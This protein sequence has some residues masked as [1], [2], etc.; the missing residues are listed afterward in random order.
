MQWLRYLCMFAQRLGRRLIQSPKRSKSVGEQRL[1]SCQNFRVWPFDCDLNLH[2][3]NGVYPLWLDLARTR[4]L[5]EIGVAP[6]FIRHGWRSVLASQTVT[7]VREIPPFASVQLETQVLHW[8]RKYLYLQHKFM[9]KGKLHASAIARIAMLKG[10]RVRGFDSML[11][12]IDGSSG[13]GASAASTSLASDSES[14]AFKI[15]NTD[16]EM[17]AVVMAKIAL[18]EAKKDSVN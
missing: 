1:H 13:E 2:L 10:G 5:L 18:L 15:K 17:P 16:S 12:A 3:T 6:L 4:W 11:R 7:F 8:D 14:I 9:V